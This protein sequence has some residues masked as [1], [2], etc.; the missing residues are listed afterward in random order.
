M[1][2]LRAHDDGG[3][4]S[5][6]GV[7]R[8]KRLPVCVCLPFLFT[9]VTANNEFA[10]F[11]CTLGGTQMAAEQNAGNKKE[12]IPTRKYLQGFVSRYPR[13]ARDHGLPA[14]WLKLEPMKCRSSF[15]FFGISSQFK[16]APSRQQLRSSDPEAGCLALQQ[17][18]HRCSFAV[19]LS[20]YY[21]SSAL[22]IAS[23]KACVVLLQQ[24]HS[25]TTTMAANEECEMIIKIILL[26]DS[27]E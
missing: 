8:L 6:C 24:Q 21:C 18:S 20:V 5:K 4:A 2:A 25:L 17:D 19:L 12:S 16:S 26:G 7:M 27:C 10:F 11:P 23:T 3:K 13:A 15:W 14:Y 22:W 1:V 9:G